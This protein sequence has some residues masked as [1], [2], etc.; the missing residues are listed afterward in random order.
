MAPGHECGI[1]I[2][3]CACVCCDVPDVLCF[4]TFVI[5]SWELVISPSASSR[6]LFVIRW[7]ILMPIN[8]ISNSPIPTPPNTAIEEFLNAIGLD[9]IASLAYDWGWLT[10]SEIQN[11]PYIVNNFAVENWTFDWLRMHLTDAKNILWLW[12]RYFSLWLI[13]N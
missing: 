9:T 5:L 6:I 8:R 7:I 10:V 12:W 13:V 3:W 1:R 4:D 2:K 11:P